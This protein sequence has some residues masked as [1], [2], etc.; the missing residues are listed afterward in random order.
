MAYPVPS[1]GSATCDES[2]ENGL[3]GL[4]WPRPENAFFTES[5]VLSI[6]VFCLNIR[7]LENFGPVTS[8]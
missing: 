1:S 2:T 6:V 3:T 4:Y 8:P 7:L 5:I